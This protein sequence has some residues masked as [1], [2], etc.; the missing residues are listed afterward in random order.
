MLSISPLCG[1]ER[2]TESNLTVLMNTF[3][4]SG[5]HAVRRS[6]EQPTCAHV[7]CAGAKFT[8][9]LSA[10]VPG[11]R[12]GVGKHQCREDQLELDRSLM[13]TTISLP[14]LSFSL[15]R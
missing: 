15:L 3:S 10:H 5:D 11:V 14:V 9:N 6:A 8:A 4:E 7:T 12:A 2:P 1:C 13:T